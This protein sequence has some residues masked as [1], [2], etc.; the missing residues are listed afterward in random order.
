[1]TAD[2]KANYEA[3]S[4]ACT[5]ARTLLLTCELSSYTTLHSL[6]Y[7]PHLNLLRSFPFQWRS[8]YSNPSDPSGSL[9][10]NVNDDGGMM[11]GV[12]AQHMESDASLHGGKARDGTR[13]GG[14]GGGGRDG[15][16]PM[17]NGLRT[18]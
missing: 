11:H 2:D 10:V 6:V 8:Q 3:H 16:G 7:R 5:T 18:T 15:A 14:G 1:M 13:G 12:D 17:Y 9:Y 4:G